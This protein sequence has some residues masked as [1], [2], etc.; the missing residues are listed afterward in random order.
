MK[1]DFTGQMPFLLSSKVKLEE[2]SDLSNKYKQKYT[3][4]L[5]IVVN[6]DANSI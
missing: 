3:D 6:K 2:T 1:Q 4:Y 5:S